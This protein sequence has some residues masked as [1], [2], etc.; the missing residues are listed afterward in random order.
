MEWLVFMYEESRF[1]K[2]SQENIF[3]YIKY[4]T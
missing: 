3:L 2:T 1:Q 4:M